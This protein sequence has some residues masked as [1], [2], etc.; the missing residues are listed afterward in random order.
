MKYLTQ[1]LLLGEEGHLVEFTIEDKIKE[2]S[3]ESFIEMVMEVPEYIEHWDNYELKL[4]YEWIFLFKKYIPFNFE[5]LVDE[6]ISG[7]RLIQINQ[8]L[9]VLKDDLSCMEDIEDY[10]KCL[11]L[12]KYSVTK[13]VR[14]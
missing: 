8:M 11:N 7:E 6:W 12:L 3:E 4:F 9:D 13:N 10:N 14:S 1:S 2:D 5:K